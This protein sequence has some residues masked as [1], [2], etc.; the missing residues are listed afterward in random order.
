[1]LGRALVGLSFLRGFDMGNTAS[2]TVAV[3]M[4]ETPHYAV[5][6][7]EFSLRECH[8]DPSSEWPVIGE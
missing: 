8:E 2:L 7:D 1:M 4:P 3:R 5:T 6:E